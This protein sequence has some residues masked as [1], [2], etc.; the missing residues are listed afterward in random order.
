M[1]RGSARPSG[2]NLI[3]AEYALN[4]DAGGGAFTADGRSLGFGIQ[5]A[6]K[7]FQ[8]YHFTARNKGGHSS[9]PR[10]D[11]AI[12]DLSAAL[13]KLSTAP[14]H[15]DAQRDHA[16]LLHRAREAGEGRARAA[17]ARLARQPER[18][19]GGRRDRGQ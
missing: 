16:R 9:R 17:D 19:R 12:Y 4:A 8:C 14:L 7:I 6:E 10:P 15:A 1:A 3:D 13:T 2:A 11:N 18:R 5:T